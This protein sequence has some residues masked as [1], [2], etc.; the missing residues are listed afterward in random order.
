MFS[1]TLGL[2]L[3]IYWVSEFWSPRGGVFIGCGNITSTKRT[4]LLKQALNVFVPKGLS[5]YSLGLH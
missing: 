5:L 4:W 2:Q 3:P 1:L